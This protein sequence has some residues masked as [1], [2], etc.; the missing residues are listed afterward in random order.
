M[1]SATQ[2]EGSWHALRSILRH[3]GLA[4]I[5]KGYG[6]TLASFGPFSAIYFLCYE[7]L[8]AAHIQYREQQIES[9]RGWR[10][11][12]ARA[13]HQSAQ[14]DMHSRTPAS[15]GACAR[16]QD[17]QPSPTSQDNHPSEGAGQVGGGYALLHGAAA[18]AL[19]SFLTN[20]PDMAKL[21]LQV[22]RAAAFQG[23]AFDAGVVALDPLALDPLE[24]AAPLAR[25][26]A[27]APGAHAPAPMVEGGVQVRGGVQLQGTPG[28]A[29]STAASKPRRPAPL[30]FHYTGFLD[31]LAS[32]V[33]VEGF[34]GLFKGAGARVLFFMPS[35]AISIACFEH[36]KLFFSG[37][38]LRHS[39]T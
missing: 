28:P 8:K 18:G 29:P 35:Q 5:Y 3:E 17:I 16:S 27:M 11:D 39:S 24:R 30:P 9:A 20:G 25:Q 15:S 33:R 10:S 23:G 21:R 13:L 38:A 6:A 31:A 34:K 37:N 1:P 26:G 19:A 7:R 12:N 36:F 22:Q 2:Y 32:I 4:A 14:I